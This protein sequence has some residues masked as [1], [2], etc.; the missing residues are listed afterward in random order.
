MISRAHTC[1]RP[2]PLHEVTPLR[3]SL[4]VCDS[5]RLVLC[6]ACGS[7][8]RIYCGQFDDEWDA[9]ECPWCEGTGGELIPTRPIDAD[10]LEDYAPPVGAS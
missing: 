3:F 2:Y 1:Y 4:T 9:G 7:E 5:P 10:D 8:G 6:D